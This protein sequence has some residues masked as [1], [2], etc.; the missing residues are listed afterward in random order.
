MVIA[1]DGAVRDVYERRAHL[2]ERNAFTSRPRRAID[3]QLQRVGFAGSTGLPV[4]DLP[5]RS[6]VH[7]IRHV[8]HRVD[9]A[10]QHA[11]T[12]VECERL[13]NPVRLA[14]GVSG[15]LQVLQ[16][17]ADVVVRDQDLVFA[18][19]LGGL[20]SPVTWELTVAD[21]AADWRLPTILVVPVKLSMP[22][23]NYQIF[24]KAL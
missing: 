8:E 23:Y 19:A 22:A 14:I 4:D 16:Q 5:Q 11:P 3:R 1:P 6:A 12:H 10:A 24:A 2:L 18:E 9:A 17:F 13:F 21:I 7:R 20:G 15:R